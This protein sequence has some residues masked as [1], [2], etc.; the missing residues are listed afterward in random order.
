M[1]LTTQKRGYTENIQDNIRTGEGV[2]EEDSHKRRPAL[3]LILH[4]DIL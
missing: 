2:K 3:S 1:R 4:F